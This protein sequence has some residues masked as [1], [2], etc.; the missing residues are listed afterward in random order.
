MIAA[1]A[2]AATSSRS[3]RSESQP[4]GESSSSHPVHG[5]SPTSRVGSADHER[6]RSLL[7]VIDRR[8]VAER[9]RTADREDASSPRCGRSQVMIASP[10]AALDLPRTVLAGPTPTTRY[11]SVTTRRR[12]SRSGTIGATSSADD[13]NRSPRAT[14]SGTFWSTA[15]RSLR[16]PRGPAL[17]ERPPRTSTCLFRRA[18]G[19]RSR[20]PVRD[21]E[22]DVAGGRRS[23]NDPCSGT[24]R[25]DRF[26]DPS[27][28]SLGLLGVVDPAHPLRV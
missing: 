8:G 21:V 6:G 23:L 16:T 4:A 3:W 19:R 14:S 27:G 22:D 24:Q 18:G 25:L 17:P 10:Y 1:H 15:V 26:R 20:D 5:R 11:R 2:V 13:V 12:I 28:A 9:R 7:A